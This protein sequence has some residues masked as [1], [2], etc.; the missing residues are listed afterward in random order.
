M[1]YYNFFNFLPT[2]TAMGHQRGIAPE[3][4]FHDKMA[5]RAKNG[6][7]NNKTAG[8]TTRWQIKQQDGR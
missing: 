3:S 8:R 2:R 4:G 6:R 1:T 7:H 5:D